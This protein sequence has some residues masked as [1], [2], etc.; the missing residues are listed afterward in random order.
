MI[1]ILPHHNRKYIWIKMIQ[2]LNLVLLVATISSSYAQ[3]SLEEIQEAYNTACSSTNWDIIASIPIG[4]SDPYPNRMYDLDA[5]ASQLSAIVNCSDDKLSE[6]QIFCYSDKKDYR[7]TFIVSPSLN[8]YPIHFGVRN[9]AINRTGSDDTGL[10]GSFGDKVWYLHD[11]PKKKLEAVVF[12]KESLED[13]VL[14]RILKN[15]SHPIKDPYVSTIKQFNTRMAGS[16][17]CD[18]LDL[19]YGTKKAREMKKE[20]IKVTAA[21]IF[22]GVFAVLFGCFII[23]LI[24]LVKR[25]KKNKV[26]VE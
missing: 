5:T 26:G 21:K 10:I 18:E 23:Y 6:I 17:K 8:P 12:S 3:L 2:K 25:D 7:Q 16:G 13:T 11:H 1:A 4:I 22:G 14:E 19:M 9:I 24:V 15:I 20:L